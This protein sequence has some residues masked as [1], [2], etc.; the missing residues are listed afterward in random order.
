MASSDLELLARCVKARRGGA[1]Q[2]ILRVPGVQQVEAAGVNL[3]AGSGGLCSGPT[4]SMGP[5][6]ER[7]D[8]AAHDP[9]HRDVAVGRR[10]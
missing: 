6:V 8:G 1:G 4:G 5:G 7:G 10:Q 9:G 2:M 3:C